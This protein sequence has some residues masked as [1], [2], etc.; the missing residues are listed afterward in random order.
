MDFRIYRWAGSQ[1]IWLKSLSPLVK[2]GP[3]AQ[4]RSFTSKEEA[5][6]ATRLIPLND[7]PVMVVEEEAQPDPFPIRGNPEPR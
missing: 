3:H 5:L 7:Q 4:A 1:P 6:Q 2:W